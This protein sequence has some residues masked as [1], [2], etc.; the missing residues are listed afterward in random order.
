M[1]WALAAALIALSAA[2]RWQY[3]DLPLWIDEAWYWQLVVGRE[4]APQEHLPV[5]IGRLIG[6]ENSVT[7]LRLP[8]F[9]AGSLAPALLLLLWRR[10]VAIPAAIFMAT[11]P[12]FVCWSALARPYAMAWLFMVIGWRFWPANALAIGC[13]PLA[14][15]GFN[16]FSLRKHWAGGLFLLIIAGGLMSLRPDKGNTG[17]LDLEWLSHAKRIQSLLLLSVLLH[18]GEL[19]DRGYVARWFC[20]AKKRLDRAGV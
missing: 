18:V 19:V 16:L 11:F 14:L 9:V 8:F 7:G 12:L 17:F 1:R 13:T 10:R 2:L 5:L 15:V 20:G 3:M 4:S 6:G